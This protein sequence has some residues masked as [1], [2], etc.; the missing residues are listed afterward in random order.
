MCNVNII[1]KY[2]LI[3][4]SLSLCEE[5]MHN[6]AHPKIVGLITKS[7]NADRMTDL[8]VIER[9]REIPWVDFNNVLRAAFICIDS[10]SPIDTEDLTVFLVLLIF[11]VLKSVHKHVGEINPFSLYVCL[12]VCDRKCV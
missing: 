7:G 9:R 6:H 2:F 5:T 12:C 3:W 4:S 11:A 1:Y 8:T 10:K